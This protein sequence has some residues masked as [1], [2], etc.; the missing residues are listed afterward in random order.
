MLGEIL[1]F[2]GGQSTNSANAAIN[3]RNLDFNAEQA[4]ANRSWSA[5]QAQKQM[6]YQTEMANTSWQR[7]VKD[8][9]AAGLSPMLAYS[10]GGAISP[11]GAMG[12]SS[13]ASAAAPIAMGNSFQAAAQ[14]ANT[15]ADTANKLA[16]NALIGAQT[17]SASAAAAQSTA[18]VDKIVQETSNLKTDQDRVRVLIDNL[19]QEGQNLF[20]QGLNLTEVGNHLR[21]TI[22]LLRKQ[23][24]NAGLQSSLIELQTQTEEAVRDKTKAQA[25]SAQQ[26]ERAGS[27]FGEMGKTVGA[28]EP[29]LRLLWNAFR[30]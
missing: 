28:L 24:L 9:Q 26:D 15:S 25:G 1:G 7:G 14:L 4:Q 21:S 29:F 30:R 10:K 8:M 17:S 6:D 22:D 20:K 12:S 11:T 2:L 3:A 16:S 27:A 19:R 5:D 13:A 18:T 23:T